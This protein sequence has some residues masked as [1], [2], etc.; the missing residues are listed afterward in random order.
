MSDYITTYT[1]VHF[2][3]LEP[4]EE[5]IQI[6]DIAH[7]LSL[8]CR[9][10]GHFPEFYSVG[11]H[12]IHCALEADARGHDR[13]TVLA[14]L[15]HDA[16][17]AYLADII[18]PV[19]QHLFPYQQAEEQLLDAIYRRYLG[20]PLTENEALIVKNI[21]DSLLYHEFYHYMGERLQETIP[22]LATQP[23]FAWRPFLEVEQ[24]YL[25]LFQKY[26]G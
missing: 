16:A 19:K 5:D 25:Q 24:E 17:E 26:R 21:D 15:L 23:V 18:R 8:L 1:K 13:P 3:P 4:K 12:C 9:A 20:R 14:C 11:Q 10:N 7:A 2:T 22:P 6:I